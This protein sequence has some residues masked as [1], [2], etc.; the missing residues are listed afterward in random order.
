[1]LFALRKGLEVEYKIPH[2][3]LLTIVISNYIPILKHSGKN[4]FCKHLKLKLKGNSSKLWQTANY[5]V[6]TVWNVQFL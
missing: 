6:E 3:L 1:M 5:F 2:K 4:Y